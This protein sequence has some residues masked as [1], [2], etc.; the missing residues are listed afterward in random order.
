MIGFPNEGATYLLI[1]IIQINITIFYT[2][3]YMIIAFLDAVGL[4]DDFIWFIAGLILVAF[5]RLD[6]LIGF[7]RDHN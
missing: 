1:K 5:D 4:W 2:L 3:I 6:R 7:L